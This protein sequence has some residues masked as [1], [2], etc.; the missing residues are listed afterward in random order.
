[1]ETSRDI[2]RR[3]RRRAAGGRRAPTALALLALFGLLLA[4]PPRAES[5]HPADILIL[6]SADSRSLSGRVVT[7]TLQDV[8]L[9]GLDD[10]GTVFVE[11]LDLL[12]AGDADHRPALHRFLAEKYRHRTFDLVFAVGP[13]AYR[14]LAESHGDGLRSA[15]IVFLGIHRAALAALPALPD[16]TGIVSSVDL[17]ST[18]R[19]AQ[20]LQPGLKHLFVV[21][22]TAPLDREWGRLA[23]DELSPLEAELD[24]TYLPDQPV[25]ELL[26]E[27]RQ[28]P[29]NSAVLYLSMLADSHGKHLVAGDM[30]ARISEASA[31]PVYGIYS[32]YV[33]LGIVGGYVES[34]DV[35][36]A[37]AARLGLRILRGENAAELGPVDDAAHAYVVDWKALK[38][39]NL[40]VDALPAGVV[41]Q[42]RNLSIWDR[43]RDQILVLTCLFLLLL[44]LMAALLAQGRR[45]QRA[46]LSLKESEDRMS[47]A[48]SSGNLGMWRWDSGSD[49][50]WMTDYCRKMLALPANENL[51]LG[52]LLRVVHP[53]DRASVRTQIENSLDLDAPF[54]SEHRVVLSDQSLRWVSTKGRA[55]RFPRGAAAQVT[56]VV[57]D[58]TERKQAQLDSEQQRLQLAHLTRVSILGELSGALAHELNQPLAAILSNAQAAQG[59]LKEA[60]PDLEETRCILDDIVADDLRAGEV[61]RRL[62]ALLKRDE[63]RADELD[64]NTL[65]E[66]SLRIAHSEIVTHRITLDVQLAPNLPAIKGDRIQLQQ[67]LLNLLVNACEAMQEVSPRNRALRVTTRADGNDN[68]E[69]VVSDTG[70]GIPNEAQKQLFE[71]FF[72]TRKQG[73]GLGLSITRAILLAHNGHI[74]AVNNEAGGASFHVLLPANR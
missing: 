36:A 57:I 9:D 60:S 43:Y 33:G 4:A 32:T 46:E 42:D 72:T 62:R 58:V 24:V 18:A 10:A 55:T 23:R 14:F 50:V 1:M 6:S 35:M 7:D 12:R 64:V 37:S 74:R 39:W 56:G 20:R 30:A 19:F 2:M 28:L 65:V 59:I 31:A 21:T 40:D 27:L 67:V 69:I 71:P 25:G 52:T 11:P 15:P 73:L 48:A 47:L 66:D 22:G 29:G 51:T 63:P 45:R 53:D 13:E 44:L 34:L 3:T 41:V 8:L 38:R 70:K 17:L 54:E 26:D 68:V 16:A 61:I 49:Q 5:G